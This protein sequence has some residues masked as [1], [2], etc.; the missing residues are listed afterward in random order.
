MKRWKNAVAVASAIAGLSLAQAPSNVSSR[1][2][3]D[4]FYTDVV[5]PKK[6][7]AAKGG[8]SKSTTSK[9]TASKKTESKNTEVTVTKSETSGPSA[10]DPAPAVT[11]GYESMRRVGL[12]YRIVLCGSNCVDLKDVDANYT[13]RSGD[14]IR[15]VFESNIDG[16]LHVFERGASGREFM[17]F[18]DARIN[19]GSNEIRRGV[20][21]TVPS[22]DW[23]K[24][25]DASGDEQLKVV[26]SRA[27]L[28]FVPKQASP[29]LPQATLAMVSRQ[30]GNLVQTRDLIF[31]DEKAPMIGNAAPA[32]QSF[33]V[34]N[35]NQDNNNLVY[36]DI[37]LRHR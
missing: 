11:A 23:F 36:V 18:P 25:S 13:F 30:L 16:Y 21:Y 31:V 14:R 1:D 4:M 27:P 34:V 28:D 9:N 26:L 33:I 10:T 3:G 2:L 22:T 7:V 15:F 24:F 12:K 35:Q 19:N 20:N 32:A 29:E 6:T 5:V 37:T 8:A 17:L